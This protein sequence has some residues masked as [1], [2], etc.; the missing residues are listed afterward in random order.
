M[1]DL[2]TEERIMD[3]LSDA[4]LDD[5]IHRAASSLQTTHVAAQKIVKKHV[6]AIVPLGLL[7]LPLVDIAALSAAQLHLIRSLSHVYQRDFDEQKSKAIVTSLISGSLPMLTM[8]GLSSVSKAMPVIGTV[9]GAVSVTVLA[10]AITYATGQVFIHHFDLGGTLDDF[11]S[12][13]WQGFFKQQFEEK[14][15]QLKNKLKS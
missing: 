3:T 14:K 11:D 4:Q 13:Q 8:L 10:S 12:K 9:G 2:T 15:L 5:E 1:D 6:A 7:P